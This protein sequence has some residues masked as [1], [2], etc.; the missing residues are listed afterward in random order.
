VPQEAQELWKS[1]LLLMHVALIN[2][3]ISMNCVD[4]GIN[5]AHMTE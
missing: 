5:T 2:F 3:D 1:E 4:L